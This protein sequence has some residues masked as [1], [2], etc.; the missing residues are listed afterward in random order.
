MTSARRKRIEMSLHLSDYT[1]VYLNR[2]VPEVRSERLWSQV[3]MNRRRNAF[4]CTD[5]RNI[6]KVAE[7][8]FLSA[9]G[10]FVTMP[11]YEYL[12]SVQSKGK[13]YA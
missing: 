1:E 12:R 3:M 7:V 5:T 2:G 11:T 10:N 8:H 13:A 9:E 6:E 4:I